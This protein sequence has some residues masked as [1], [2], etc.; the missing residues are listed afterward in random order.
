LLFYL[1]VYTVKAFEGSFKAFEGSFELL[2]EIL[3]FVDK[4]FQMRVHLSL[5]RQSGKKKKEGKVDLF[6]VN[7]KKQKNNT[8]HWRHFLFF[9][10]QTLSP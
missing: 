3:D 8:F 9:C 6:I 1:Y 7:S 5:K 4:N 2:K 10:H